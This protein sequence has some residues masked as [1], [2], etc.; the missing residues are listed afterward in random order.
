MEAASRGEVRKVV[1]A[2]IWEV[3]GRPER[4][5]IDEEHPCRPDNPY[6][7]TKFAGERLVL[8]YTRLRGVPAIA[9]RLGPVYGRRMRPNS[10]FSAFIDQARESKP[11]VIHGDGSQRRQFTHASDVGLAFRSAV[12]SDIAGEAYNVVAGESI[13]VA[14]PASMIVETLPTEIVYTG[15]GRR[16]PPRTSQRGQDPPPP[17]L[18]APRAIPGRP[19]GHHRGAYCSCGGAQREDRA[20]E[21]PSTLAPRHN[22]STG[23]RRSRHQRSR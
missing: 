18:A 8:A 17:G 4:E 14:E 23:T 19:E 22:S 3:Y 5:P 21:P 2:S 16:R 13:A 6:N 10:V 1:Y 15:A 9:L 11:I 20:Y 7:I 12:E